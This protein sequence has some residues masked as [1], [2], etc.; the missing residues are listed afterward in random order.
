MAAYFSSLK[1]SN[2]GEVSDQRDI[3]PLL[4]NRCQECHSSK[5]EGA[6]KSGLFLESYTALMKGTSQGSIVE[7]GSSI[8]STL[9]VMVTRHDNLRMPYGQIPLSDEEIRVI[10]NWIDQG[11]QDN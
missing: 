7:A 8:S 9:M 2:R 11:A 6:T 3:R 1:E 5:G 4:A 10:K